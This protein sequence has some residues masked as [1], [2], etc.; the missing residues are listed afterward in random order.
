MVRKRLLKRVVLF[1]ALTFA[2]SWG[3]IG[4]GTMLFGDAEEE[5]V[6]GG[7]SLSWA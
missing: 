2:F 1:L 4:L 5:A 7:Y 3:V 6:R